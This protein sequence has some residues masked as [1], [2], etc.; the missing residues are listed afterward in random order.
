MG[1]APFIVDGNVL[2]HRQHG[3]RKLATL[4]RLVACPSTSLPH[5][6]PHRGAPSGPAAFAT[7]VESVTEGSLRDLISR[8]RS[9]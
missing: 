7:F 1:P 5:A 2:L 6:Q 9:E 4:L 8:R 3:A